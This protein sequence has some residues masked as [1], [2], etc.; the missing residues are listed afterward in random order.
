MS[1]NDLATAE[2]ASNVLLTKTV[3]QRA[4]MRAALLYGVL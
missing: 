4:G 3:V 1:R 2:K